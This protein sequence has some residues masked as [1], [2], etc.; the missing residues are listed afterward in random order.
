MFDGD[1]FDISSFDVPA[2][3]SMITVIF[4]GAGLWFFKFAGVPRCLRG[5]SIL[6][7][8]SYLDVLA[9]DTSPQNLEEASLSFPDV[10]AGDTSPRRT[11]GEA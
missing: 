1:I 9:G 11:P 5:T 3:E 6:P 8:I 10:P 2:Y 4:T 7:D